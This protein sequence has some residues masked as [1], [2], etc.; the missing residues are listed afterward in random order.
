MR[1]VYL[2][3]VTIA[4]LLQAPLQTHAFD[5][6]RFHTTFR[7]LGSSDVQ[8]MTISDTVPN[9]QPIGDGC[10]ND[11]A[12][13]AG[14][15]IVNGETGSTRNPD[16]IL[17]FDAAG[18][19]AGMQSLI[20]SSELNW[21]CTDN[22]F[23]TKE[24]ITIKYTHDTKAIEYCMTTIYFRDPST[25]CQKDHT[26]QNK[27]HLQKGD[28]FKPENLVTFPETFLEAENDRDQWTIDNYFLG[29]GHHI[30]NN[31]KDSNDCQKFMPIQALYAYKD[32]HCHNTGFVWMHANT[33]VA[34]PGWEEPPEAVVKQ[35]LSKPAQCQLDGARNKI[36]KT[37][38]VFLGGSTTYCFTE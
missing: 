22:E 17:I 10:G 20:P 34:G 1:V 14:H 15:R 6:E 21:D 33:K 19:A 11:N 38:H 27:L 12:R 25:I 35:I 28:S 32:G 2:L 29:M 31:E 5:I 7:L 26:A 24:N 23:Y 30:T 3:P 36:S 18:N 37:M 13:F 9:S 16:M 4:V 8:P